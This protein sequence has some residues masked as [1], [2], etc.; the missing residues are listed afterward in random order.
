MTSGATVSSETPVTDPPPV[1]Q[2]I[3]EPIA[4]E[5]LEQPLDSEQTSATVAA[6]M[7]EEEFAEFFGGLFPVTATVIG[8]MNNQP[9]LRALMDAPNYASARP[10]F[11]ALYRM[12]ERWDFL[13]F[14]IQRD[15]QWI[16]DVVL[17][18]AFGAQLFDNLGRELK[19]RA[20]ERSPGRARPSS[21]K[22]ADGPV[23]LSGDGIPYDETVVA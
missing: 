7:S 6:V 9:P 3:I 10:A 19:Q 22:V 11:G 21:I 17:V 12:A 5:N 8:A 13:A 14:L 2:P 23:D 18:G 4:V 15:G 1:D 20:F 16:A